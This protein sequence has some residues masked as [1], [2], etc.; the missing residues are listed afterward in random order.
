MVDKKNK[1]RKVLDQSGA[2]DLFDRCNS[3]SK[4]LDGD[5]PKVVLKKIG[6]RLLGI[7]L[8]ILFSPILFA[9]FIL[10]LAVSL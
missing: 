5:T 9:I 8:F 2:Q 1:K 10:V 4:I 6:I 7:L 3:A